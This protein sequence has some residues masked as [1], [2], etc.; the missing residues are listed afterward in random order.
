MLGRPKLG[1]HRMVT[2]ATR[3][4]PA[5]VQRLR[6]LANECGLSICAY[7]RELVR[8]ELNRAERNTDLHR[9]SVNSNAESINSVEQLVR[10]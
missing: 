6:E 1:T 3:V 7:V 2:V 10:T 5:Q 9:R 4:E 8:L